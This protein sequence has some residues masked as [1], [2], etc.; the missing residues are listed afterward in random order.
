MLQ[1]DRHRLD[2]AVTLACSSFVNEG[3]TAEMFS[4]AKVFRLGEVAENPCKRVV[5]LESK[6][7]PN[8]PP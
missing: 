1:E 3:I 7:K 2:V 6:L 4:E 5:E 8:T